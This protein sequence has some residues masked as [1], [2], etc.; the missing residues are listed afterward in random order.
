MGDSA[1]S[2]TFAKHKTGLLAD[3]NANRTNR[4]PITIGSALH[5]VGGLL[6]GLAIVLFTADLF[7]DDSGP[8]VAGGSIFILLGIL[9]LW[10]VALRRRSLI[11]WATFLRNY[12]PPST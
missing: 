8:N 12:G 3:L 10:F 4:E 7:S 6:I 9:V 1:T 5:A 11:I 2:T